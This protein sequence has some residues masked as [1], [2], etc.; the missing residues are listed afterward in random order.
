MKKLLLLPLL[1]VSIYAN[2]QKLSFDYDNAGNQIQRSWCTTCH[3][4]TSNETPK[5]ISKL[6]EEDLQ[7]MFTIL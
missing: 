7:K 5:E 3:S 2:A 1:L 6:K 4:R